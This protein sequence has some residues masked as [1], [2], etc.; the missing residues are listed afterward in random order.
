MHHHLSHLCLISFD[1]LKHVSTHLCLISSHRWDRWWFTSH[2]MCVEWLIHTCMT[3]HLIYEYTRTSHLCLISSHRWDRW[4][5]TSHLCLIYVSSHLIDGDRDGDSHLIIWDGDVYIDMY[6]RLIVS[7]RR[8]Y[9][10]MYTWDYETYILWDVY[11]YRR[12]VMC[13][14]I[15]I[16]ICIYVS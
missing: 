5:F 9:I 15:C 10:S 1:S 3:S 12:M 8:I 14:S 13:T 11:T 4:W 2:L 7:M 16:S 6:I